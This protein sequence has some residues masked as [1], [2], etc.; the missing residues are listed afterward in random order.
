MATTKR[1]NVCTKRKPVS[2][3]Y[4]VSRANREHGGTFTYQCKKCKREAEGRRYK[5]LRREN[6]DHLIALRARLKK[7]H[8]ERYLVYG[9]RHRLKYRLMV[10]EAYGG[11]CKCCGEKTVEFLSID[12]VNGGGE[13][14]RRKVHGHIYANLIKRGFPSGFRLLCHNCNLSRGFYGYCPHKRKQSLG[15]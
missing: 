14:H 4:R 3:F 6:P 15:D 9:K 5:K 11:K 8:P 13:E 1:C 10:I 7:A 12:H 2:E